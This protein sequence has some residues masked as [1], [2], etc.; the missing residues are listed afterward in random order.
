MDSNESLVKNREG[1]YE[2]KNKPG[3]EE[4]RDLYHDYFG[5]PDSINLQS[6]YS[7][8]EVDYIMNKLEQKYRLID[9]FPD[10][11]DKRNL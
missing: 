4:L 11:K 2:V 6:D 5:T 8:E 7:E 1:Y 10:I 3:K 9:G